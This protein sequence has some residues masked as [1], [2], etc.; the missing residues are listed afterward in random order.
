MEQGGKKT[1]FAVAQTPPG[2]F[3]E[4]ATKI[5]FVAQFACRRRTLQVKRSRALKWDYFYALLYS[6]D[7]HVPIAA[8]GSRAELVRAVHAQLHRHRLQHVH[9]A[10]AGV[11]PDA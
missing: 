7:M 3:L 5:P 9:P 11:A 8:V 1:V 4:V 6:G 2:F 10:G